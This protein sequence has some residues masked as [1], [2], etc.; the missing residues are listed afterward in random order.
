MIRLSDSVSAANRGLGPI[1]LNSLEPVWLVALNLIGAVSFLALIRVYSDERM[2]G[3][4]IALAVSQLLL[5]LH[6]L[7]LAIPFPPRAILQLPHLTVYWRGADAITYTGEDFQNAIVASTWS[8]DGEKIQLPDGRTLRV[9]KSGNIASAKRRILDRF[10]FASQ[11]PEMND[12]R[13]A[14]RRL[15]FIL[16]RNEFEL[17]PGL[18]YLYGCSPSFWNWIYRR[19]WRMDR[20][21]DVLRVEG[22]ELVVER[23]GKQPLRIPLTEWTPPQSPTSAIQDFKVGGKIYRLDRSALIPVEIH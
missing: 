2:V 6:R 19:P 7:P 16:G 22:D 8:S 18:R 13:V 1:R 5:A 11:P 9:V 21:S 12:E 15:E 14:Q 4:L 10:L 17:E 23:R 3:P 20:T